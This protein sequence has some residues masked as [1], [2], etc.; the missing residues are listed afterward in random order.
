MPFARNNVCAEVRIS[1]KPCQ[2]GLDR[3]LSGQ[4]SAP[5]AE[6]RVEIGGY[7]NAAGAC[8]TAEMWKVSWIFAPVTVQKHN[9]VTALQLG[10]DAFSSPTENIDSPREI[11]PLERLLCKSR[12]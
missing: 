7:D 4:P 2:V 8:E 10:K 9:I 12:M 6:K 1:H 3:R 5:A 11:P